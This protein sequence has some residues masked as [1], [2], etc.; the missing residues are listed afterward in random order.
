ME[1]FTNFMARNP[2]LF[3]A[4]AVVMGLLVWNLFSGIMQGMESIVPVQ[5]VDLINHQNA[6]VLDV[7]EDN[8]YS[9]GH[10]LNAVHVPLSN[11][12]AKLK[13]LEKYRAQPI[14]IS[15]RSG[16]RS[17]QACTLLKKNGFEKIYNLK[18]GVLAWQNAN[19]P[20]LKGKEAK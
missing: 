12:S 5:A 19:L 9:E 20:L 10:I 4:I 2:V 3:T 8:E 18:G 13:Q 11:L 7:R 1:E 15:C 14:V 6:I 17:G 16:N